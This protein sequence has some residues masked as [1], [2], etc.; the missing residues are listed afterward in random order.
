LLEKGVKLV[1][2]IKNGMKNML[3]DL[4]EKKLLRKRSIIETVNGYLKR[5]M[6]IEHTRHR[7]VTNAFIHI[8][9][10]L[11]SYQLLEGKPEITPLSEELA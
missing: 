9:S 11:V 3:M 2:G 6:S 5:T 4:K 7:S 8:F 10:T 1:T